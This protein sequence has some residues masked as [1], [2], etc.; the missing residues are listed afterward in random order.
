M[1]EKV[2]IKVQKTWLKRE[3]AKNQFFPLE[4]ESE[5][6]LY[7]KEKER[8]FYE[9]TLKDL[10]RMAFQIVFSNNLPHPFSSQTKTAG[11]K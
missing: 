2:A 4:L 9:L 7:C 11:P 5:L 6:V 10:R 1:Y 3:L 8:S